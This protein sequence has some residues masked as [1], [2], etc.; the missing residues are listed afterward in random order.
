MVRAAIA[1]RDLSLLFALCSRPGGRTVASG[2]TDRQHGATGFHGARD[3]GARI[4]MP[5]P[6]HLGDVPATFTTDNRRPRAVDFP[7]TVTAWLVYP[8]PG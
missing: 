8:I 2:L 6:R 5:H 3:D 4:F 1:R 7:A